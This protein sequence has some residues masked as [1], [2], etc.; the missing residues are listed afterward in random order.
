M[1]CAA[2]CLGLSHPETAGTVEIQ[3]SASLSAWGISVTSLIAASVFATL[4]A[5]FAAA[6]LA[7]PVGAANERSRPKSVSPALRPDA[8]LRER[9]A[10]DRSDPGALVS[11]GAR[12]SAPAENTHG[13]GKRLVDIAAALTLL[14]AC[15]PLILFVSI[16]IR[17]DSRGSILFRQK[18]IG[19]G[20]E[21]FDML[22][23]RSMVADAEKDGP[24]W[25][26]K[27]DR[28]V[29]RVGRIIRKTRIDEIPQALNVLRGEMSFVGPRPERPE[30]VEILEREIPNYHLRHVVKP[31]ITGLAQVKY[32]YGASVED[33]RIKLFYDL[34]YI[35]EFS[36]LRDIRIILATVRVALFGLGSR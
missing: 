6:R 32:V 12:A 24:Q 4:F 36:P 35:K 18:R 29:T 17:L 27:D 15:A 13:W 31:G 11:S 5:I 33:A 9:S 14:A 23:F 3:A 19:L 21:V 8:L 7:R 1:A 20:G 26:E 28:R 10:A 2:P 22:K 25:A 16:A 34:Q 30:F